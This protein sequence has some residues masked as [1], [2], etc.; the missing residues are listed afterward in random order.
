MDVSASNT[1]DLL[2]EFSE[3]VEIDPSNVIYFTT[4][5]NPTVLYG[6]TDLTCVFDEARRLG[7]KRVLIWSDGEFTMPGNTEG[8]DTTVMIPSYM[9]LTY[10]TKENIEQGLAP[11]KISWV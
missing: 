11:F 8:M 10:A 9:A 6:G 2:K 1:E 7:L 4:E 5:I 3:Q